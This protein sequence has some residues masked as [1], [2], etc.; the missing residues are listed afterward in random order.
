M[1]IWKDIKDYEGYQVSNMGRVRSVYKN[2]KEKMLKPQTNN[3]YLYVN[4]YKNKKIKKKYIHR[5]VAEAF[6]DDYS[7]FLEVNHKDENKTNNYMANLEMCTKEYNVNYGTRTERAS[8]SL[9]GVFVNRKDLSNEVFGVNVMDGSIITFLST[10]E[11]GR[12]GFNQ[13]H[14]ASCC[15]GE[16]K[17]KTHQGYIWYYVKDI[18]FIYFKED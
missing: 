10:R 17:H 5:L 12:N 11:A 13:G 15:R 8:K 7:E 6:L 1:E 9:R 4:L 16:K 3:R 14:L 2:G 18:D